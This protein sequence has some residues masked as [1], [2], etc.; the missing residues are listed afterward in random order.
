[1]RSQLNDKLTNV[2]VPLLQI[3]P[4][5]NTTT[6][7]LFS[8]THG[9]SLILK[10]SRQSKNV[11]T[12]VL[13]QNM[14]TKLY[15]YIMDAELAVNPNTPHILVGNNQESLYFNTRLHPVWG[16]KLTWSI[17]PTEKQFVERSVI[18]MLEKVKAVS[19][20]SL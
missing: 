15:E 8:C 18:E 2:L 12:K 1:M 11:D 7:L 9:M 19:T 3:P 10:I 17:I 6:S 20:F 4:P 5:K 16:S 13:V 14:M